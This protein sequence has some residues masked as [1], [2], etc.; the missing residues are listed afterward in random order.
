M[1][2][3]KLSLSRRPIG[4]IGL[5]LSIIVALVALWQIMGVFALPSQKIGLDG[6]IGEV[7]NQTDRASQLLPRL[8]KQLTYTV[9]AQKQVLDKI[10]AARNDILA[11]QQVQGTDQNKV[12]TAST[13]TQVAL[14]AFYENYP[15]FGIPN[16]QQG[17]LDETSGSF[18]RIAYARHQ[19]IQAQVEYN[20]ARIGYFVAA[21][22]NPPV[23]ILGS[24]SSP[25]KPVAPSSL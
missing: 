18:N 24:D 23:Q 10:A 16:I 12:L 13:S 19:L 11:T 15:N 4:P 8:E 17:L 5:T 22:F 14:K 6:K 25:L 2:A 3:E 20:Q 1:Y 7:W 21:L 9:D